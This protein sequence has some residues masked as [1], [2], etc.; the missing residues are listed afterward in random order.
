[1]QDEFD[2]SRLSG[3]IIIQF[4]SDESVLKIK[5]SGQSLHPIRVPSRTPVL[6]NAA[7]DGGVGLADIS[8]LLRLIPVDSNGNDRV[9]MSTIGQSRTSS[10]DTS[11]GS[12]E[13]NAVNGRTEDESSTM[14]THPPKDTPD[15]SE[16][17]LYIEMKIA[18][19]LQHLS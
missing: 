3:R 7:V 2:P 13:G 5:K 8:D 11:E 18:G 12:L 6:R 17:I 9:S 1:M 10:P 14:V 16:T 19:M 15:T 4:E